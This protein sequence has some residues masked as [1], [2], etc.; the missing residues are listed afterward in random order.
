MTEPT[1]R[2]A[3]L[4]ADGEMCAA[5]VRFGPSTNFNS[6]LAKGSKLCA[7]LC[8]SNRTVSFDYFRSQ[9]GRPYRTTSKSTC[10]RRSCS[11]RDVVEQVL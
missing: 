11:G 10:L 2:I 3:V 5:Y 4:Q 8:R 9:Q 6:A 7:G 1:C